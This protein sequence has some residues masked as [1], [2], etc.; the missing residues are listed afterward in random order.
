M[1]PFLPFPKEGGLREGG[2]NPWPWFRLCLLQVL[3]SP[4]SPLSPPRKDCFCPTL[5]KFISV[6]LLLH[7]T[8]GGFFSQS[9]GQEIGKFTKKKP[10][11]L[12]SCLLDAT[13]LPKN[14]A[15]VTSLLW[16]QLRSL[17]RQH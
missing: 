12:R 1:S 17:Y 14:L 5:L 10:Q 4:L 9:P 15:Q 16:A 7:R 11:K 2:L 13:N 8:V 3:L 6:F